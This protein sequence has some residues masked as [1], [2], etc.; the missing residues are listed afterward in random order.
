MIVRCS[1][2]EHFVTSTDE[3]AGPV[4][5]EDVVFSNGIVSLLFVSLPAV[6]V[7]LPQPGI[8]ASL[9]T[10]H[11]DALIELSRSGR[12]LQWR[13][14]QKRDNSLQVGQGPRADSSG[15]I[16]SAELNPDRAKCQRTPTKLRMCIGISVQNNGLMGYIFK[17]TTN[18]GIPDAMRVTSD[19]SMA[20]G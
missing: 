13:P 4:V 3:G 8:A 16:R 19:E 12:I 18:K 11:T 15:S 14:H 9:R 7:S 5:V 2:S 20:I 1:H 6:G 17:P 10:P